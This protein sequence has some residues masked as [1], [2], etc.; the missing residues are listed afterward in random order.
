MAVQK[1]LL[2]QYRYPITPK[3]SFSDKTI[4]RKELIFGTIP[5]MK[6]MNNLDFFQPNLRRSSGEI[7]L[8]CPG[9]CGMTPYPANVLVNQIRLLIELT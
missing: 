5:I 4:G 8:N 7:P 9:W 2:K 6:C 3:T 1:T